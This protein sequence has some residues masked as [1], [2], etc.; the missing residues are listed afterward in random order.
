MKNINEYIKVKDEPDL[1]RDPESGAIINI[2]RSS[3]QKARDA[4][5]RRLAVQSEED[6]LRNKVDA[7]ENDISD[8]KSLLSQLVEKL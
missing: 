5:K 6:K 8:I 1:A 4:K 2:N 7:L 3:I